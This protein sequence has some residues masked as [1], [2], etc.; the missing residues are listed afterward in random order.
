MSQAQPPH[1]PSPSTNHTAAHQ[2][3]AGR[4]SHDPLGET[5]ADVPLTP[6][7]SSHHHTKLTGSSLHGKA[8]RHQLD[9]TVADTPAARAPRP[10]SQTSPIDA[11]VDLDRV[12]DRVAAQPSNVTIA[13][14]DDEAGRTRVGGELKRTQQVR[15][16]VGSAFG[17]LLQALVLTIIAASLAIFAAFDQ[18]WIWIAP[19]AIALPLTLWLT[20]R[21]YHT[22]LGHRRYMYRLL[23]TLGEDV[24]GLKRERRVRGR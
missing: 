22:W 15:A 21:R 11:E 19:A 18:R 12:Y 4:P 8:A 16:A 20:T 10:S 2:D 1:R 5:I 6:R 3:P 24:S 7:P 17:R 23:D 9:A 13:L 14:N